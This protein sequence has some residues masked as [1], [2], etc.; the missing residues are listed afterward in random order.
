MLPTPHTLRPFRRYRP[1]FTGLT[2]EQKRRLARE[3][4]ARRLAP[5]L[6][7]LHAA[8]ADSNRELAEELNRRGMPSEHG[9]PWTVQGVAAV[10]HRLVVMASAPP[11][12]RPAA[13]PES[14]TDAESRVG[15]PNH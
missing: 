5:V 12:F 14:V 13:V 11:V 4:F 6:E 1:G 8:G 9:R 10:R 15:M 2:K 7:E 3:A